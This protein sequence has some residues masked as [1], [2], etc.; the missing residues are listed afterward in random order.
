LRQAKF[1][2]FDA[3]SGR[4]NLISGVNKYPVEWGRVDK[5]CE[6][7]GFTVGAVRQNR[8]KGIW[9]DG[10]ITAIKNRRLYVNVRKYDQCVISQDKPTQSNK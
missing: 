9:L 7:T 4:T 3:I 5:F 1:T 10:Q 2:R 8:K 6:M